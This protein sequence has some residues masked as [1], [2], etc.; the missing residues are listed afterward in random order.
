[1]RRKMIALAVGTIAILGMVISFVL[2]CWAAG[3][4]EEDF[5]NAFTSVPGI[6]GM[7]YY[8]NYEDKR[9]AGLDLT[10]GRYLYLSSFDESVV[11][12]ADRISIYQ[13]GDVVVPCYS[14]TA[15]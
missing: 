13:I 3:W 8:L 10:D 15:P 5:R 14:V 1:M 12:K 7:S 6:E 9:S 2:M 11:T 4:R